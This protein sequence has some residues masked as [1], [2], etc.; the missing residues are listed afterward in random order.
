MRRS[1]AGVASEGRAAST[2]AGTPRARKWSRTSSASWL[3]GTTTTWR[4][5]PS[6]APIARRTGSASF[7]A[8]RGR[9]SRSSTTSPS[10]TRRSTSRS[11]S[12]SASSAKGR[13]RTSRSTR[14]PRC[15]SETTSVRTRR[16]DAATAARQAGCLRAQATAA[17]AADPA[18]IVARGVR[19]RPRSWP[20]P[21]GCGRARPPPLARRVVRSP[22][23]GQDMPGRARGR[24][25]APSGAYGCCSSRTCWNVGRFVGS[26]RVRDQP[27]R[28]AGPRRRAAPGRRVGPEEGRHVVGR[29]VDRR[30]QRRAARRER[31]VAAVAQVEAAADGVAEQRAQ[32]LVDVGVPGLAVQPADVVEVAGQVAEHRPHD[33]LGQPLPQRVQD[34]RTGVVVAAV[35]VGVEPRRVARDPVVEDLDDARVTR[36]GRRAR[37]RQHAAD[38]RPHGR[39]DVLGR[40]A[41]H[42]AHDVLD[43]GLGRP[44]VEELDALGRAVRLVVAV[45]EAPRRA[46]VPVEQQAVGPALVVRVLQPAQEAAPLVVAAAQRRQAPVEARARAR[47]GGPTRRTPSCGARRS[48]S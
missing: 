25:R 38:D 13:R 22:P 5:A 23:P 34:H 9:C 43:L 30:P 8:R 31:P 20:P 39:A 33:R 29:R 1:S 6:R 42:D 11:A 4:S 41:V 32:V 15:R 3:P 40:R 28:E 18:G 2:D 37:R 7:I 16:N 44:L 17:T 14:A 19:R 10:R 35:V 48:P 12:S 45:H 46:V 36:V 21:P 47:G 27:R 24:S 26:E